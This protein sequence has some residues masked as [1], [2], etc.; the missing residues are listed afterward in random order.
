MTGTPFRPMTT[1][2][3]RYEI[4]AGGFVSQ[5]KPGSPTAASAGPRCAVHPDG[6]IIC[7]FLAQVALGRNDFK[8]MI[9]RSR[10]GG[11]TWSEAAMIWP[12]F[13]DRCSIFGSI[14][15]VPAGECFFYGMRTPI[16]RPGEVA[17]SDGS[18]A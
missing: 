18:R 10:D 15:A 14:S 2:G 9:S 17:W 6:T 1:P 8:P 4:L 3:R 16:E 12:E 11:R 13:A 5:R 7:T